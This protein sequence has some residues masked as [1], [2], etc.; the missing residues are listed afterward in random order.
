M[1]MPVALG[2]AVHIAQAL[3]AAHTATADDGTPLNIVH[4]DVS[5]QNVLVSKSGDVKLADF[6][7]ASWEQRTEKTLGATRGKPTYMAPEQ[8]MRSALDGRADVFSLGCTLHSMLTGASLLHDENAM[9]DLLAGVE[10]EPSETLPQP[11]RELIRRATRRD[12][13]ARCATAEAFAQD[14]SRVLEDVTPRDFDHRKALREWLNAVIPAAALEAPL[15]VTTARPVQRRRT[16]PFVLLGLATVVVATVAVMRT[17]PADTA[18]PVATPAPQA[19]DEASSVVV[20][21]AI[22]PPVI[23]QLPPPKRVVPAAPQTRGVLAIGGERFLKAEVLVDGSSVGF[24]PKQLELI[25]G[26]HEV[27]VILN[28]GTRVGPR[29]V[30]VGPQHTESSPQRWVE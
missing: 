10:L 14:C 19:H 4:R 3:H 23:S 5:P 24:A 13:Q 9:V 6:G 18:E 20:P 12:R 26:T 15:A 21:P 22:T 1:P 8:T 30:T 27:V 29:S 17:P 7:I 25:S 16:L 11:V 2:I 28:D